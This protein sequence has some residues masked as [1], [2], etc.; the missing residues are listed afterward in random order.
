[1]V[2]SVLLGV[3]SDSSSIFEV[4][5]EKGIDVETR[6]ALP[7]EDMTTG[8][9]SPGGSEL[10]GTE[11][12]CSCTERVASTLVTAMFGEWW[13][14]LECVVASEMSCISS[15]VLLNLEGELLS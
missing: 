14:A 10:P 4:P 13:L 5:E 1:M 6:V 11:V 2:S 8:V 15:T 3:A 7:V 9:V 12:C